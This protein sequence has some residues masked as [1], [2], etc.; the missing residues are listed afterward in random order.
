[1]KINRIKEILIKIKQGHT[2]WKNSDDIVYRERLET[3]FQPF[4]LELETLG[5]EKHFSESLLFFG[6]EFTDSF[7]KGATIKDVEEIFQVEAVNLTDQQLKE[8][9]LAE[10]NNALIY[11]SLP[12]K[13]DKVGIKVLVKKS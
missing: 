5:V 7:V 6:K 1:M 10:K 12:M 2:L 9:R 3:A 8:Y 13:G 4:F 11:R